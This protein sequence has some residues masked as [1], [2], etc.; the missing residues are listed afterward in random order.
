MIFK[1]PVKGQ[2][3]GS[4]IRGASGRERE[5]EREI[6]KQCFA[7]FKCSLPPTGGVGDKFSLQKGEGR[8][9]RGTKHKSV[10][11]NTYNKKKLNFLLLSLSPLFSIYIE[12]GDNHFHA[13]VIVIVARMKEREGREGGSQKKVRVNQIG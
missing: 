3:Y 11:Q 2:L 9:G 7:V 6:C 4:Q 12:A 8:R 10:E 5:R 13:R 1:R